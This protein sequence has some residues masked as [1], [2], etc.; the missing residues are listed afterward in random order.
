MVHFTWIPSHV[1][2]PLNEKVDW[3]G[4]CAL[5]DDTVDPGSECTLGYVKGS[6]KDFVQSSISDQLGL[7]CHR[8]S[9]TSLYYACHSQSCAYTYGRHTASHNRVAVRLKLGYKYFWEVLLL[10]YTVCYVLHQEDTLCVIM[11]RNVLSLTVGHLCYKVR[12]TPPTIP[13]P[14]PRVH[15]LPTHA[16]RVPSGPQGE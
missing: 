14:K 5:Q 9:G 4:Q 16:R 6:I 10:V 1:G 2:I 13:Q 11:S 8:G 15:M 3:L 12:V 7:C